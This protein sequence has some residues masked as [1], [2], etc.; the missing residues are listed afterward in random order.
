MNDGEDNFACVDAR[1]YANVARFINHSCSP[2]LLKQNV[3]CGENIQLQTVLQRCCY[4]I[5]PP[6]ALTHLTP[7]GPSDGLTFSHNSDA[8]PV[9]KNV[10]EIAT[11][12]AAPPA[13]GMPFADN[14]AV[15]LRGHNDG[16]GKSC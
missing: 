14:A 12:S 3:Y 2:N 9:R 1:R 13:K 8:R 15:P 11:S 16:E 6:L 4:Q 10:P 7:Q 5:C